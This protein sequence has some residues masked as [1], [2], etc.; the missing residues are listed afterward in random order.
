[1]VFACKNTS[2]QKLLLFLKGKKGRRLIDLEVLKRKWSEVMA[3]EIKDL[4]AGLKVLNE[5]EVSG[6]G[7][8]AVQALSPAQAAFYQ[9]LATYFSQ[10]HPHYNEAM[11]SV[12]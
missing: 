9:S 8:G 7:G 6:V 2:K 3:I 5:E 1:L 10:Q 4:S 11:T 12:S